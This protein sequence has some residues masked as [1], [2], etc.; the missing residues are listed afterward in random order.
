VIF[1]LV[2]AL[3]WGLA[4]FGGAVISRRIGSVPTVLISQASGAVVM[5]VVLV[6]G[7]QGVDA[8]TPTLG[9]VLVGGIVAAAAYASHYRALQ[10]GPVSVVSPIGAAYALVGVALAVV[11]LGERLSAVE[12]GGAVVTVLGVMLASADLRA[13]LE[14]T[15]ERAPGLPLALLSALLFG[16]AGY[17]LAWL[18]REVGW[19]LALWASRTMLVVAL[20]LPASLVGRRAVWSQVTPGV[21]IVGAIAVGM[22]D[23]L[24][25]AT[26]AAGAERGFVSVVIVASSVFPLIAVALSVLLLHERPVA[27]QY[28]GVGLVVVGLLMLGLG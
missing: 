2:A 1:G 7:G 18:S 3:G 14:G 23:L 28:V 25:V 16:V 21:G 27:N 13:L 4:D 6:L 12:L 24:G 17:I 11:L 10:L 5:A 26:Y 9:W 15:H 8:L 22:A 20:A 19:A